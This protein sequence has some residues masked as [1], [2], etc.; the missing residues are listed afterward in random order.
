MT[1]RLALFLFAVRASLIPA[2]AE[3]ITLRPG[4]NVSAVT[5]Y[6]VGHASSTRAESGFRNEIG[7]AVAPPS[8]P[9]QQIP[10]RAAVLPPPVL[11]DNGGIYRE[12]NF[13]LDLLAYNYTRPPD[14]PAAP[15]DT[16][17]PSLTGS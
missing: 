10:T 13:D 12:T 4:A 3:D 15:G 11:K 6:A 1:G 9:I 2:A 7:A 8:K 17:N 5:T 16:F 14:N